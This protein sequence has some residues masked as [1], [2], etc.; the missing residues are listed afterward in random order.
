MTA[1]WEKRQGSSRSLHIESILRRPAELEHQALGQRVPHEVDERGREE[2][3][4]A[5]NHLVRRPD[6]R[7]QDPGEHHTWVSGE[8]PA[9]PHSTP[10]KSFRP[11]VPLIAFR[12]RRLT[13]HDL[14]L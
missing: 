6:D 4:V 8:G 14:T 3:A 9:S 12:I 7:S 10:A 2:R 5:V 13:F 1:A 11:A